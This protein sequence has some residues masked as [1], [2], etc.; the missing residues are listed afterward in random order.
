MKTLALVVDGSGIAIGVATGVAIGVDDT[1]GSVQLLE[2]ELVG[3]A[4][5]EASTDVGVAT[6]LVEQTTLVVVTVGA[7]KEKK[8]Y[9]SLGNFC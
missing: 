9:V 6:T 7:I 5:G 2:G 3:D 8:E 1:R 4:V